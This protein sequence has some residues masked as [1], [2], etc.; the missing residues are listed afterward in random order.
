MTLLH[1]KIWDS[2]PTPYFNYLADAFLHGQL[3][4]RL[5]PAETVDLVFINNKVYLYWPP[6]PAIL[7]MPWVALLGVGISD[8]LYNLLI[9]SVNVGLIALLLRQSVLHRIISLDRFQRGILVL[10]FALG[11]VHI[12]ISH[13][14]QVWFTAQKL[15]FLFTI[16]AFLFAITC[17]GWRAFF[18][19]G[20]CVICAALTRNH[21]LFIGI[22]PA[23]HLLYNHRDN[24]PSQLLRYSIIGII[25]VVLLGSLYLLY[26]YARFGSMFDIGLE[27]HQ[28]GV[29]FK[30]DFLTYGAFHIHF[31]PKNLYYHFIYYPFPPRWAFF[32]GGSLFLLSP[33]F[34]GAFWGI[35]KGRPRASV[36]FLLLT[37]TVIYIPISVLFA[38][39]WPQFG[40]R[41]SLDFTVPLLLLTAMGVRDWPNSVLGLLTAISIVH[42]ISGTLLW[43]GI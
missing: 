8:I 30:K 38:P 14:G 9:A 26:N 20:L 27:Y 21:L 12:T 2:S 10:F 13:Q 18:L 41:Y 19:T 33:V 34:F 37:I 5:I 29:V 28:L 36:L 22:W 32:L 1:S 25:P 24:K 7:L 40:P 17:R 16:L 31:L 3:H 15:A 35:V 4:L 6:L 42:Y 43:I 23:Y 39:G 11:T